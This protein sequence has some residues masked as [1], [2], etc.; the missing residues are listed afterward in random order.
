MIWGEHT[1]G[2]THRCAPTGLCMFEHC[3]E[4]DF[5]YEEG[6]LAGFFFLCGAGEGVE[7][8]AFPGLQGAV[9]VF[10]EVV[11]LQFGLLDC[12]GCAAVGAVCWGG[13]G[14]A[15]GDGCVAKL[16]AGV[17]VFAS[18]EFDVD[19]GAWEGDG[20]T[21]GVVFELAGVEVDPF[22]FGDCFL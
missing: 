8:A 14:D 11:A 9:D 3:L 1:G 10:Y 18:G 16:G 15:D 13:L 12:F 5:D 4:V 20:G 19:E 22:E 6:V 17:E 2:R 7:D 21:V